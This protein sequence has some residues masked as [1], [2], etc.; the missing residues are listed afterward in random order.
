MPKFPEILPCD[1]APET[2]PDTGAQGGKPKDVQECTLRNHQE[3]NSLI[4][5]RTEHMQQEAGI[6]KR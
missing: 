4:N 6:L 5:C 2:P 1:I 3:G